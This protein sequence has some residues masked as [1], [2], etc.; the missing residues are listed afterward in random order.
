MTY[1]VTV[2]TLQTL[3]AT[4]NTVVGNPV[5]PYRRDADDRLVAIPGVYVLDCAYG[6]Y[7]L[8]QMVSE[9]GGERNITPRYGAAI[10]ADL[11]RAYMQGLHDARHVLYSAKAA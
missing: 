6:G 1:R 4:L 5:D 3:V 2:K 7:R 11:I 8:A 9:T 10:T